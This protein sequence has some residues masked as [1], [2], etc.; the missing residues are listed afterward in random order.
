MRRPTPG[1][2]GALTAYSWVMVPSR[3]PHSRDASAA[4]RA[5]RDMPFGTGVRTG[6]TA[7]DQCVE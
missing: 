4:S 1:Q 5:H 3:C 7:A 2:P 6:T